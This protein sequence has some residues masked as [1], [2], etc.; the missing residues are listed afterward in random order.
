MKAWA[1]EYRTT[2]LGD[3]DYVGALDS[4]VRKRL[5]AHR[6]SARP[7]SVAPWTIDLLAGEVE[8]LG[9]ERRWL[10]CTGAI[11]LLAELLFCA[12]AGGP[13]P[14]HDTGHRHDLDINVK[15]LRAVR[16]ATFHPAFQD[17]RAGSGS[18]PI[19]KL[20]ELLDNDDDADV[21]EA[22]L[23]LAADW[24]YLDSRPIT[25]YALRMLD[26]GGRLYAETPSLPAPS[27][28]HA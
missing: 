11:A 14:S 3:R 21:R 22:A 17:R 2:W 9:G 20:Y 13:F 19:E 16:N 28:R 27:N 26:S 5:V 1:E 10:W 18:P 8:R 15:A 25:S 6:P 23:N 12:D 24:S 4:W 7:E